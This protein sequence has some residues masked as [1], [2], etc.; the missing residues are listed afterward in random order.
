MSVKIYI[1]K[2][3]ENIEEL[4]KSE[5]WTYTEIYRNVYCV[6]TERPV[7][8]PMDRSVIEHDLQL[9]VKVYSDTYNASYES[10]TLAKLEQVQG[11]P[12]VIAVGLSHE[13]NY[14]IMTK[15]PGEELF[16]KLVR[17]GP[18][19]EDKSRDLIRQLLIIIAEVHKCK[20]IH[21]DIKLENLIYNEFPLPYGTLSLID[22]EPNKRTL[23]YSPPEYYKSCIETKATD[24]WAVG[25][26]LYILLTKSMPFQTETGIQYMAPHLQPNWSPSLKEFMRE[27]LNKDHKKRITVENALNHVWITGEDTSSEEI[28]TE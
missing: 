13:F 7:E 28:P 12:R 24:V 21:K 16:D 8:R 14:V 3:A 10:S 23:T 17:D 11:V 22:F 19:S 9:I 20:I 26:C 15:I 2:T 4:A 1:S 25:I 5:N 27:L 6:S 18:F